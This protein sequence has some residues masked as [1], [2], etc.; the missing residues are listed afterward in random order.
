LALDFLYISYR[1]DARLLPSYRGPLFNLSQAF[2]VLKLA[3]S[4]SDYVFYFA[5][6]DNS[7]VVPDVTWLDWVEA[8]VQ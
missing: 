5:V 6:D 4:A 2:E 8:H 7:D 1:L 3:L